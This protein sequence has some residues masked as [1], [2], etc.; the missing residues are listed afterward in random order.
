MTDLTEELIIEINKG[1]IQEWLE[2][3]PTAFEAVNVNHDKLKEI[4]T[5]V[6]KQE[7]LIMKA[8]YLLGGI[9][10]SQ[11]FSGGNKRTA[12][13]CADTILRLNGFRFS[14]ESKNEQEHL[15]KLLLEIQDERSKL[16]EDVMAKI[17]LYVSKRVRKA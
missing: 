5:I 13:V 15:R 8:A 7:N 4:L 6:N 9:S 3:N 11:P 14:I 2:Q 1:I 10:W 17:I 16:N 12:F